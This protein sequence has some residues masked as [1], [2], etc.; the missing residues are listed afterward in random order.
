[1]GNNNSMNVINIPYL[2][3]NKTVNKN[4]DRD[5]I[6]NYVMR[7]FNN[8]RDEDIENNRLCVLI[9]PGNGLTPEELK[10]VEGIILANGHDYYE[11]SK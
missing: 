2:E 9:E 8:R 3:C 11:L 5:K 7:M 10:I 1:M 6:N 4:L